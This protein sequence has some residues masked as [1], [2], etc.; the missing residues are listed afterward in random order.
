MRVHVRHCLIQTFLI[1]I[2][3]LAVYIL[4]QTVNLA[5]YQPSLEMTT[6]VVQATVD[7]H[8]TSTPRIVVSPVA[9]VVA[10]IVALPQPTKAT[11]LEKVEPPPTQTP[12]P[13][14][15]LAPIGQ[16]VAA[17][18]APSIE[19]SVDALAAPLAPATT[20][21]VAETAVQAASSACG[22]SASGGY[23]LIPM[24]A[25]NT[26]HPDRQHG[27]LNLALRGTQLSGAAKELIPYHGSVDGGAPQLTGL[28]A[29]QRS[30]PIANV[31]QVR[32][33]RWDCSEH[34]CASDWL[35][36]YDVTLIGLATTP[37]EA[38][39]FPHREAEIYGGGYVA[40]VLYAEPTRLTI[41]YTRDGTVA[42]GYATHLENLCVDPNLLALYHIGNAGGRYELPGLHNGQSVG[43]AANNELRVAIRD[44]GTFMDPRSQHDWWK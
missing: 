24:E 15:H 43:V 25:A 42:N 9:M 23:T 10:R 1:C 8:P 13:L 34:G 26:N 6:M 27:D 37:G 28:F 16:A 31:Y 18:L 7:V 36:H 17:T 30:G 4:I 39:L 44:R 20:V 32:D 5:L 19:V 22:V 2:S 40:V 11:P 38:I 3:T 33:W 12:V 14:L 41:A 35:T 21:A 29:D